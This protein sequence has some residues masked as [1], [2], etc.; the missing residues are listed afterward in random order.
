MNNGYPSNSWNPGS[1]FDVSLQLGDLDGETR[2]MVEKMMYDQRQKE[3]SFIFTY[4]AEKNARNVYRD[5]EHCSRFFRWG[6]PL[7]TSKRSRTS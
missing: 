1:E 5:K 7:Q 3:V 4:I 2:G 6:F